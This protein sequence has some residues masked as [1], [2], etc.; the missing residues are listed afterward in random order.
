MKREIIRVMRVMRPA[1][2]IVESGPYNRDDV[3]TV[4]LPVSILERVSF[5]IGMLQNDAL[6]APAS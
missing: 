1:F 3:L 4:K 6:N 5:H 2:I